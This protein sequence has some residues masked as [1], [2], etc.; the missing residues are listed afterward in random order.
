MNNHEQMRLLPVESLQNFL[1]RTRPGCLSVEKIYRENW[2]D[3]KSWQVVLTDSR[4]KNSPLRMPMTFST[5]FT[6]QEALNHKDTERW[7]E[8]VTGYRLRAKWEL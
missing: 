3:D 5:N 1:Q 6:E 4:Y 2:P 8:H 7:L